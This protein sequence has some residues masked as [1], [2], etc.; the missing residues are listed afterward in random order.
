MEINKKLS[1]IH[2]ISIDGALILLIFL[3]I[4]IKTDINNNR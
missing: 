4:L 3:K 1:I 2:E